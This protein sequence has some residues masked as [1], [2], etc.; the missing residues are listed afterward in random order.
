MLKCNHGC[1]GNI[2]CHDKSGLNKQKAI[3]QLI[4]WMHEDYGLSHVEYS[5]EGSPRKVIC[6]RLIKTEDGQPPND[7]KIFCSYGEPK[8][9][10]VISGGHGA[11]E[12]LDYYTIDWKWIPVQNGKLPNAGDVHRKPDNL[13]E[14]LKYASKLS[15]D[16]PIVR[17]DLY[18]EFGRVIF[19]ELTF[20]PTGGMVKYTPREY[21]RKF[22]D[23]FPLMKLDQ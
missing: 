5:Y 13:D 15:V 2:L 10:Y 8:L 7:Y 21:D 22:G 16:F 4:K 23:L 9:I 12:C 19:G 6:E 17:V 18:S 20:L 3:E 14:L 1:G 11:N